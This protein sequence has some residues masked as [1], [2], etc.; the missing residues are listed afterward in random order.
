MEKEGGKK[1]KHDQGLT[2][3]WMLCI[4]GFYTLFHLSCHV[5]LIHSGHHCIVDDLST[6]QKPGN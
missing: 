6:L 4:E 2:T 1:T 3:G 5:F